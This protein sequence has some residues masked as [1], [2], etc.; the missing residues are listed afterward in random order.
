MTVDVTPLSWVEFLILISCLALRLESRKARE[1][2]VK[3]SSGSFEIFGTTTFNKLSHRLENSRDWHLR[4]QFILAV[5]DA[6]YTLV[7][8]LISYAFVF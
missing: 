2:L 5:R 8:R 3:A 7:L 6:F 4:C 1:D